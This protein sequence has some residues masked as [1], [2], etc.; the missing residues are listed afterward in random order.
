[1][2]NE[3]LINYKRIQDKE[4]EEKQYT[5][6]INNIL[7]W[8]KEMSWEKINWG[9]W[10]MFYY[11]DEGYYILYVFGYKLPLCRDST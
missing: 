5:I 4:R 6:D 8:E 11:N 2:W 3:V 10:G 7:I 9:Q 1:M